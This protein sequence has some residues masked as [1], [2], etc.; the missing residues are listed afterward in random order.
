MIRRLNRPPRV[1]CSLVA[2]ASLV[3][4]FAAPTAK[5]T[6]AHGVAWRTDL[7]AAQA[8]S[9]ARN[10]PLWIQFTGPWCVNCRRMERGAFVNP[11]VVASSHEMFVPVK[12]RSDEFESL[13]MSLGLTVLPST[14]IVKP[15]GEVIDKW[16]GYGDPGEFHAW[17]GAALARDGRLTTRALDRKPELALA[18]F[19]PVSLVDRRKLVPGLASLTAIH[20]GAEYRFADEVSRTTFVTHPEKYAPMNRG[21]CP[22]EH[23]DGGVFRPG[24]PE[25]GVIYRGHLFLC[26]DAVDRDRFIKNPERY[27]NVDQVVRHSCPHC[28]GSKPGRQVAQGHDKRATI[29]STATRRTISP[30]PSAIMEAF[31]APVTQLRR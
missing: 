6:D 10:L 9:R 27:A 22:V 5:A 7:G 20:N 29:P 17:L 14:V 11:A 1:G 23:V 25:W 18:S 30:S 13:A 12:L 19:C 15:T 24:L 21:E 8:E 4:L 2:I 26:A 3:Q 28:W 31:L 16:E